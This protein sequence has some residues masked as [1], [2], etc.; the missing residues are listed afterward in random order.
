MTGKT[1][2]S[3]HLTHSR[4]PL[5]LKSLIGDDENAGFRR[6][7]KTMNDSRKHLKVKL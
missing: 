5:K 1:V 2:R 3:G 6:R 4:L 7:R